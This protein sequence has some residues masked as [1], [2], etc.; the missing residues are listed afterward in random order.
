MIIKLIID[1]FEGKYA[2]LESQGKNPMIFNFPRHL[3]PKEAKEGTILN[4]NIDIDHEETKRKKDKIQNLL[5]KLKK[6]D[7]G[8][9]IQL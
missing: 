8:G 5:D 6:Q 4:I 3:L 9:D 1:R 7:K 2:I